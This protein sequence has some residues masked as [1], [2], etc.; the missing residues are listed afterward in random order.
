[1]F[2][3]MLLALYGAFLF[4]QT[5]QVMGAIQRIFYIHLPLAWIGFVAFGHACWGAIQY[6]RTGRREWDT[7]SASAAEI[8]VLFAT[9]VIVTGSLWARPVWGTWWTW[10][11]Q[12]V[13]Y[14]I[15]W[16]IYV[17]YLVLR[18]AAGDDARQARFAAVFAIVGFVD[19]PLVWLSARYLRALSP[20]IFT[21]RSIGLAPS[22]AWALLA[23]LVAWSLLYVVLVRVRISLG[24]LEAQVQALA[25]GNV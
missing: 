11:P 4:A 22:M 15:L 18:A 7:V 24:R 9:L 19:V 1:V 20:V 8:G 14:L 10:D 25:D 23:G 3:A 2:I 6:L 13:T 17:G 16:F 5:E 12:L 21:S